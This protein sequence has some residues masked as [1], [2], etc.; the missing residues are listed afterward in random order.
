MS[1]G[2]CEKNRISRVSQWNRYTCMMP[3]NEAGYQTVSISHQCYGKLVSNLLFL[4]E[5]FSQDFFG[6]CDGQVSS[7][8]LILPGWGFLRFVVCK[9]ITPCALICIV[10][11]QKAHHIPVYCKK[12]QNQEEIFVCENMKQILMHCS[13]IVVKC[14]PP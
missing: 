1:C 5:G 6:L 8:V 14:R 12:K 3:H 2:G 11:F 13:C 9:I 7:T 10:F 4:K